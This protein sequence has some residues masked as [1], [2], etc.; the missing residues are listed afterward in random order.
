MF[1]VATNISPAQGAFE[2]APIVF[3]AIRV[4]VSPNVF[5]CVV[6][7]LVNI[8]RQTIVRWERVCVDVRALFN[9]GSDMFM[10]CLFLGVFQLRLEV[11]VFSVSARVNL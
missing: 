5:S 8:L 4:D 6:N 7:S 11:L 10:Q 2:Q 9:C 3:D 1:T